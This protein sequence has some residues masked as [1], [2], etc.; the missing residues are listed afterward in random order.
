MALGRQPIPGITDLVPTYRSILV[1]YDPMRISYSELEA[2]IRA[3]EDH[4]VEAI[5]YVPRVVEVPT[6]YGGGYGPDLEY[7]ASHCGLSIEEVI[8]IHSGTDYLIYMMGFTPGFTYLGGMSEKIAT[9]RL[10]TPRGVVPAG[11]VGIAE[12]QTGV[13]PTESP[14]GWQLIGRTP[15]DLFDPDRDPP[16]AVDTGDYLRF[17][18]VTEGEYL[19]IQGRVRSGNYTIVTQ[20]AR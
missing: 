13:Y 9:P 18:P 10:R 17:V 7:V 15:L 11:S 20:I 5:A 2:K 6:V 3:L 12:Q 4:S 8:R 1:Y 19:D 14:G 16:V